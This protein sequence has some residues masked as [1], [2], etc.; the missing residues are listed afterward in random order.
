M[1]LILPFGVT[2]ALSALLLFY[3]LRSSRRLLLSAMAIFV[4]ATL[5]LY[6]LFGAPQLVPLMMAYEQKQQEA[7]HVIMEESKKLQADGQNL[8]SWIR[9][10]QAFAHRQQWEKAAE[11]FKQAVLLTEGQPE[12][13][14]AYTR[15]LIMQADGNVTDHAHESL[16]MVLMQM[17]EHEEARYYMAL[18]TLQEGKIEDAMQQMKSLY[19][20]LPEDSPVRAMINE[21]IGR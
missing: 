13:I 21:Q 20:E 4:T 10:G 6:H 18:R 9:L 15:S 3:P 2:A 19:R 12:L 8:E 11:A 1:S 7:Q 14:M 5:G 16:K 17:P